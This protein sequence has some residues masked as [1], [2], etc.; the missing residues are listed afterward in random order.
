MLAV[1]VLR[2]FND[3][4]MT[5]KPVHVGLHAG[6]LIPEVLH[7]T[8]EGQAHLTYH[9]RNAVEMA[10]AERIGH[11]AEALGETAGAGSMDLLMDMAQKGRHG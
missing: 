10:G 6:E 9:V 2:K 7:N 1:N 8:T 3:M 11:G 5:R 4:D